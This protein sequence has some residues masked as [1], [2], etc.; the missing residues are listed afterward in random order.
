[1]RLIALTTLALLLTADL[2]R[3]QPQFPGKTVRIVVPY[4]AGGGTDVLGRL[5]ADQLARKWGQ[6]VIVENSGGAAGNIGAAEVFRAA[7][8]GHT[9][10]VAAPGPIA[11][12]SFLYK[13]MP[14]DPKRW[15]AIA[16]L[17][18]GPYVLVL[19]K[20]FDGSTV[21]DF[22]AR[23]KANPDRITAAVQ[24]EMLA[25]IK[26]TQVPY[27]G[28]SPAIND[29]IAGHV[30]LMFDTPTT[31]LPLHRD[32]K[33]R[34]IATGTPERLREA[35]DIP[36]IAEAGVSGYRAITWY[37]LVGP[38]NMATPLIARINRDVTEILSRADVVERVRAIQ[39]E[40]SLRTPEQSAAFFA[41]ESELWGKVIKQAN[42][43]LQ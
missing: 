17:T 1:M 41:D 18:T 35:S 11:T 30:D 19:R 26:T 10:M 15:S 36:T 8:D 21:R 39:M 14:F 29:L 16:L 9:L 4:P 6:S 37:A 5:L 27:R 25:G 42:I 23:A 13:D 38:P 31:A 7:P 40:P 24:L 43:P 20:S 2:S 12:N 22:I 33:V 3:A 28:L 32:G 34:I